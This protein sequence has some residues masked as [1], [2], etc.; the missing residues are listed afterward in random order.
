MTVTRI[1]SI[2][3]V[4]KWL[5]TR[6]QTFV[7]RPKQGNKIEGVL[8]NRAWILGIFCPK[9]GQGFK[10]SAAHL[11]PNIFLVLPPP[12]P[13]AI[14]KK[15]KT[16]S[17]LMTPCLMPG[18]LQKITIKLSYFHFIILCL[19]LEW[20]FFRMEFALLVACARLL[21]SRDAARNNTSQAKI[22]C[23]CT[24]SWSLEHATVFVVGLIL[25]WLPLS[26]LKINVK[27]M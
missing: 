7:F 26:Y 15:K 1:C 23:A 6:R 13:T 9:Q 22:R 24:L 10:A 3:I 14:S 2:A 27:F 20:H 4:N 12:P 18:Q 25:L 16:L 19:L 17:A 21:D 11:Y 8:L 5:K